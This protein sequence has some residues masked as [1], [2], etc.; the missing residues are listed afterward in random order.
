M[1]ELARALPEEGGEVL[2]VTLRDEQY[3][4]YAAVYGDGEEPLAELLFAPEEAG[5]TYVLRLSLAGLAE[6]PAHL[7]V[8]ASDYAGNTTGLDFD[9]GTLVRG[10]AAEPA[11]C[12]AA[13]FTD[14]AAGAWYHGAV[15]YVFDQGLM[16]GESFAFR[17]GAN[18]SRADFLDALYRAA[19]SPRA[20]GKLPFTDVP[21]GA[22][23]RDA[24]RWAWELGIADG[25]DEKTFGALAPLTRQQLAVILYRCATLGE[26][27]EAAG[28]LDAFADGGEVAG[29]AREAVSWAVGEGILSGGSGGRLNPR[30]YATRGELAAILMRY[31]EN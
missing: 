16:D 18:A 4:A 24:V 12:P 6:L 11:V 27:V 25:F 7:C 21:S 3:L 28:D 20:Q 13:M 14:V 22:W 1:T 8:T 9:L 5:K 26:T 30:G 15:D 31:L 23:Y 10:E 17:P 19:G 29:W 2:A